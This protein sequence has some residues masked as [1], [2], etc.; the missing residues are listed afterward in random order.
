MEK[1]VQAC[2]GRWLAC[3]VLSV[4]FQGKLPDVKMLVL[5]QVATSAAVGNGREQRRQEARLALNRASSS[6]SPVLRECLET[7]TMARSFQLFFI[8]QEASG[9]ETQGGPE[10]TEG[11]NQGH[12]VK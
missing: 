7:P 2:Q 5:H 4:L 10:K 8:R 12:P 3:C 9:N 1:D 11:K 6:Q